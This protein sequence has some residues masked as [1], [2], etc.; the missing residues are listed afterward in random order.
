M[1]RCTGCLKKIESKDRLA[2]L[3]IPCTRGFFRLPEFAQLLKNRL[4][5]I[6]KLTRYKAVV[7]IMAA[8]AINTW[9]IKTTSLLPV[10][11]SYI[12]VNQTGGK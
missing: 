2:S 6:G 5:L 8:A 10:I 4:K 1:P 9:G 12:P 7:M 3:I 11:F